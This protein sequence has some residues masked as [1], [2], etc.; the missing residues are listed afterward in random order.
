MS[1]TPNKTASIHKAKKWRMG[2]VVD[3]HA[4]QHVEQFVDDTCAVFVESIMGHG[5]LQLMNWKG[6]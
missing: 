6:P 3:M 2:D 5:D 1:N 4:K